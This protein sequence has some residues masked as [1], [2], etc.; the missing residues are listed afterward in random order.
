M[1]N[2]ER[3]PD[4]FKLPEVTFEDKGFDKIDVILTCNQQNHRH[5]AIGQSLS[6]AEAHWNIYVMAYRKVA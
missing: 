3:C 6:M 1:K 2:L 4:C 5:Q